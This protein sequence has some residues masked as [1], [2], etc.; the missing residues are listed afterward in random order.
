[1]RQNRG[2]SKRGRESPRLTAF[3]KHGIGARGLSF[4]SVTQAFNTTTSMGRLTLNVPPS[5]AQFEREVAGERTRDKIAASKKKSRTTEADWAQLQRELALHVIAAQYQQ[6][7]MHGGAGMRSIDRPARYEKLP[8][9][10]DAIIL[11]WDIGVTVAGN[12]TVCTKWGLARE[13]EDKDIL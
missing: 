3:A 11:S 1:V 5:F 6:R 4:V 2:R 9:K 13:T 8:P 7:P 10:F 12:A